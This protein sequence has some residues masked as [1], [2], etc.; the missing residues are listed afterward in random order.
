MCSPLNSNP[1]NSN[2][3]LIQSFLKSLHRLNTFNLKLSCSLLTTHM[4]DNFT[5]DDLML[6]KYK[7]FF[8]LIH[9]PVLEKVGEIICIEII[10]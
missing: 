1:D 6:I 8:P 9:V 5:E 4:H 10:I 2:F 3:C 7:S